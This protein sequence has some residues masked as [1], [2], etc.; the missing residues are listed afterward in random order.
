VTRDKTSGMYP[1]ETVTRYRVLSEEYSRLEDA[2]FF[3][4]SIIDVEEAN[5]M[6]KA[7][8]TLAEVAERFPLTFC[9]TKERF[10]RDGVDLRNAEKLASIT[11]HHRFVISHWQCSDKPIYQASAFIP[12]SRQYGW[13]LRVFGTKPTGGLNRVYGETLRLPTLALFNFTLPAT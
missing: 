5:E 13:R 9:S 3:R 6:W 7:G 10:T 2:E 1:I 12:H 4:Q 11:V 8:A